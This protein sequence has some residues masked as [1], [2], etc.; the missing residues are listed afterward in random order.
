M[1][2]Y[3]IT[4][5]LFV[6]LVSYKITKR[7]FADSSNKL[8]KVGCFSYGY[9][10]LVYGSLTSLSVGIF[11]LIIGQFETIVTKEKFSAKVVSVR[12]WID[13]D[14]DGRSILMYTPT[15]EF[16]LNNNEII[17]RELNIS[18]GGGYA[19]GEIIRVAYNYEEDKLVAASLSSIFLLLGGALM[20]SFTSILMV[21]GICYGFN[22]PTKY[23]GLDIIKFFFIAIFMPLGMLVLNGGMIYYLYN[24]WF[25][26]VENNHP[27]FVDIIC[28]FFITIL[29][30][31]KVILIKS[32]IKGEKLFSN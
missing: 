6:L 26:G 31:V 24:S 17:N 3:I 2:P 28:V 23:T 25:N 11:P 18:S 22:I 20:A 30:L 1:S 8:L 13:K 5:L 29:T 32:L 12:E 14:D 10:F 27:I 9:V 4:V 7:M 21:Y 16:K 15:V 19:I